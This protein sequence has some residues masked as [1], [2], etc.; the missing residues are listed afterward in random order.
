DIKTGNDSLFTTRFLSTGTFPVRFIGCN[1]NGCDTNSIQVTV[2]EKPTIVPS[3]DY[4]LCPGESVRIGRM[5]TPVFE[6][7]WSPADYLDNPKSANPLCTPE[8]N[9]QYI[10]TVKNSNGCENYDTVN[11]TLGGEL[12][13][14][15]GADTSV[16]EGEQ[17]QLNASGAENFSWSPADGLSNA[18][19]ANP[20]FT[21]T[22]TTQYIVTGKSGNCE[23][24]DTI[25]VTVNEKPIIIASENREICAGDTVHLS[26]KGAKEYSWSPAE[27]LNNATIANPIFN[28]TKTTEYIVTGKNGNCS[29]NKK[30]IIT[31]NEKPIVS[32][33]ENREICAGDTV[34]LSAKGALEYSWSPAEGL[35]NPTI[36]NPIF[37]GT[38]TTEYIVTGKTGT[39]FDS[40]KILITVNEKP[41]ISVSENREICL[42]DTVHLR[43]NNA[44]SYL[45]TPSTYLNNSTIA[46]PIAQPTENITYTVRGINANGCYEEKTVSITINNDQEKT[47]SLQLSDTAQYAPGT[48]VPV[49]IVIPAGL[50]QITATLNY[51]PCC[52][53]CDSIFTPNTGIST[54]FLRNNAL[55]FT[56]ISPN[57]EEKEIILPC[58]IYLPPDGRKSEKFTLSDIIHSEQCLIVR[59]NNDEILYDPSCAWQFRGVQQTGRFGIESDG[60]IARLYTGYGGAITVKIF[61]VTGVEVW[62]YSSLYNSTDM[63]E[64]S[65]PSLSSG[66]YIMQASN[67]VWHDECVMMK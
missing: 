38:K 64:I 16:C 61:D 35:N 48:I 47:I 14:F 6:Y 66:M 46:N 24:K 59:G 37:I 36:A 49:K 57:K 44:D 54:V 15:A 10:L 9:M 7:S 19:I 52:V 21:G 13:V 53:R 65:L 32:V 4:T 50:A 34:H 67:G 43:A 18:N 3:P 40:K 28:G 5:N 20:I 30:V 31:V 17:I 56:S 11:V 8:K 55:R 29:D 51:D 39:C 12:S 42:G 1:A 63:Q 58:T 45:W 27:G 33:S 26:A 2:Y 41:T 22:S 23:G 60:T 25:L 62:H